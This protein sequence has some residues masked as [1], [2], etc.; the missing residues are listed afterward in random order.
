MEKAIIIKMDEV[1]L[2]NIIRQIIREEI[3]SLLNEINTE[4]N[5]LLT[6]K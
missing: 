2:T 6:R 3:K 1:D 4:D 5:T